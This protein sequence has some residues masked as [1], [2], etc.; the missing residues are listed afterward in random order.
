[1]KMYYSFK[2]SL[3]DV[4]HKVYQKDD[5]N[6]KLKLKIF[7]QKADEYSS[8]HSHLV[9]SRGPEN[10]TKK[11]LN[12]LSFGVFFPFQRGTDVTFLHNSRRLRNL[13]SGLRHVSSRRRGFGGQ[14]QSLDGGDSA[15][16]GLTGSGGVVTTRPLRSM[17]A[18]SAH[19][20]N[21]HCSSHSHDAHNDTDNDPHDT[22]FVN[23]ALAV[24]NTCNICRNKRKS[25][26]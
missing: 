4:A 5:E 9:C 7:P 15:G 14:L 18:L 6:E 10:K 12:T 25:F 1:M 24:I 8:V 19:Q 2:Q 3:K 13:A 26:A 20:Y 11:C 16:I 17:S 21:L 23:V 22:G